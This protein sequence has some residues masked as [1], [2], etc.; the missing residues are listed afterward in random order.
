MRSEFIHR[1]PSLAA[2]LADSVPGG[3][4][5]SEELGPNASLVRLFVAARRGH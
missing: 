3:K 5:S 1:L 4:T 2:E